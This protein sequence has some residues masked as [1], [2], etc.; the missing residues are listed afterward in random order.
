MGILNQN[1]KV[2]RIID[3]LVVILNKKH[4]SLVNF[5]FFKKKLSVYQ[6]YFINYYIYFV[7]NSNK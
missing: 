3:K 1:S 4:L 5:A 6:K 2:N 7:V